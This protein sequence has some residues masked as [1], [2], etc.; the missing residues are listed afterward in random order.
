MK[1]TS[2]SFSAGVLVFSATV[3]ALPALYR[4]V[5][6]Q[7]KVLECFAKA[8]GSGSWPSDC[9]AAAATDVGIVRQI[10]LLDLGIDFS[11]GD[12]QSLGISSSKLT[13]TLLSVGPGWPVTEAK[14]HVAIVDNNNT[15]G[16]FETNFTSTTVKGES[17]ESVIQP[18]I[19]TIAPGQ[20]KNFGSFVAAL[21]SQAEHPFLLR[22][23][24]DATLKTTAPPFTPIPATFKV[25]GVGFESP[26]TLRGC[27]NFPK[28]DYVEQVG[29]TL[30][31]NGKTFTLTSRFDITNP[32]QLNLNLGDVTFQAVNKDAVVVGT[33]FV[34]DMKLNIGITTVTAV[35]T[36]SSMETY[37]ALLKE[38]A[39]L[40]FQGFD[41]SS[42]SPILVEGLKLMKIAAVIPKQNKL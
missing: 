2:Y 37:D 27:N 32:S 20:A 21:I 11:V 39:T 31:P 1:A 36:S 15:I 25:N 24:A 34:K 40:T 23:N 22:G 14:Y 13:A 35:I 17:L 6:E 4:R 33:A 29:L 38:G 30:D 28:V 7:S 3:L 10:G 18:S 41:G 5:A 9:A 16:A 26:I 8:I 12:A 42:A 19:L